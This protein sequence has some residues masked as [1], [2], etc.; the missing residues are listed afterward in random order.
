MNFVYDMG[1]DDWDCVIHLDQDEL[2]RVIGDRDYTCPYYR[3]GD[4]YTIVRKQL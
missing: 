4:D 2:T 3:Q 1:Y